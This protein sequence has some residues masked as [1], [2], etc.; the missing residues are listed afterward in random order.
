MRSMNARVHFADT[1]APKRDAAEH[2]NMKIT[3]EQGWVLF[4]DEYGDRIIYPSHTVA[5]IVAKPTSYDR[6]S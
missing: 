6:G 4:E 5:W 3:L 1:G 2:R